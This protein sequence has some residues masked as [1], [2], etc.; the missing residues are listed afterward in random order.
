MSRDSITHREVP[1]VAAGAGPTVGGVLATRRRSRDGGSVVR[2]WVLPI[3]AAVSG[4]TAP[5][6]LALAPAPSDG[7]FKSIWF[8]AFCLATV[9]SA[10]CALTP[11]ILARRDD[12]RVRMELKDFVTKLGDTIKALVD[13]IESPRGPEA[14]QVFLKSVLRDV[15]SLMHVE[16]PRV[17]LYGFDEVLREDGQVEPVLSYVDHYGRLDRPRE[18]FAASSLHGAAAIENARGNHPRLVDSLESATFSVRRDDDA[19]WNSFALVPLVVNGEPSGMMTIDTA[20]K[21]AFS[22]DHVVVA[23]AMARFVEI[24]LEKVESGKTVKPDVT[25]AVRE[26]AEPSTGATERV[27]QGLPVASERDRRRRPWRR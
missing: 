27:S 13:L 20:A 11:G 8:Y 3:T 4:A 17:C 5:I 25:T 1:L 26:L 22:S 15:K 24:G 6:V 19:V 16:N 21:S 23:Q 10:V 12:K 2:H 18:V 9:I 7:R 14:R